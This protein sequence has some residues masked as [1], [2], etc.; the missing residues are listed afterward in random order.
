MNGFFSTT[1]LVAISIFIVREV[2][3]AM[4]RA[5]VNGRRKLAIKTLLAAEIERNN[6]AV[7]TL[8]EIISKVDEGLAS[9][10]KI[11]IMR[12]PNGRSR[13]KIGIKLGFISWQVPHVHQ[14]V[15]AKN[16][17]DLALL[18]KFM[19]ELAL[20]TLDQLS[21][22]DHLR[23]SLIEQVTLRSE[24][25]LEH[26]GSFSSYANRVLDDTHEKL[27][28]LYSLCTGRTLAAVRVR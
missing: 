4:R 25:Q 18:D 6:Y 24:G 11:E 16:I 17:M 26:L 27:E 5:D 15:L 21:E 13:I 28:R 8:R 10:E 7:R 19:F 22:L 9:K 20:K 3:E 12:D 23:G 14:E 2:L 1:V